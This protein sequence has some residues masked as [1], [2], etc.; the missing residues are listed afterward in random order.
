MALKHISLAFAAATLLAG[1]GTA[2]ARA[3]KRLNKTEGAVVGAVAGG[4]LGNIIAGR[5]NRTTG[6][7]VGAGVG[8]VAGHE[9]ARNKYNKNCRTYRRRR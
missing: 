3:C 4:V 9:I 7:L 2:E 5:G 8:G 6:T 1:A